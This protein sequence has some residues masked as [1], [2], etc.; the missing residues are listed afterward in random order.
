MLSIVQA[1]QLSSLV[2]KHSLT[3][4]LVLTLGERESL[5]MSLCMHIFKILFSTECYQDQLPSWECTLRCWDCLRQVAVRVH[6]VTQITQWCWYTFAAS[7][8][9]V[10]LGSPLYIPFR[11]LKYGHT[12]P[13]VATPVAKPGI[14]YV[15]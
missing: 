3:Q 8:S 11:L 9:S 5:V 15:A 4:L 7:C 12:C 2:T 6:S 13:G 10:R 14:E 1:K